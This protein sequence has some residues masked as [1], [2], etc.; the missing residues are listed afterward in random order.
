MNQPPRTAVGLTPK[1]GADGLKTALNIL[2]KWACSN[3][4]TL[5]ILG[6]KH[7]TITYASEAADQESLSDDQIKR[8]SYILNI[9]AVLRMLFDNPDN[10]YRFMSMRNNN[11]Y[12][13]GRTPLDI[14]STGNLA[15][16]HDVF[17]HLDALTNRS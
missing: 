10:V 16:L 2:E 6:M 1:T 11:P 4:Q 3:E 7:T 9:H 5:R 14:I 8:I 13:D 17:A 12:F 15:S